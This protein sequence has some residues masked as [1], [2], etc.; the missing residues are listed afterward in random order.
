MSY[1]VRLCKECLA[2]KCYMNIYSYCILWS[3]DLFLF[4]SL[5]SC[6]DLWFYQGYFSKE[7]S[8]V[9]WEVLNGQKSEDLKFSSVI[10]VIQWLWSSTAYY[11]QMRK[12]IR[13]G[14]G[15]SD[16]WKIET[17]VIRRLFLRKKYE[18][19]DAKLFMKVNTYLNK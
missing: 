2:Y 3:G 13:W 10:A 7:M 14:Q 4:S 11:L 1:H 6:E 8:N 15:K 19:M 17:N 12:V 18:T 16:Y 5:F 9:L